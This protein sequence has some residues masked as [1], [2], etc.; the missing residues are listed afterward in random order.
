MIYVTEKDKLV[1]V[2]SDYAW[3]PPLGELG[4]TTFSVIL[5]HWLH[6][7]KHD[8]TVY[9][10]NYIPECATLY[11]FQTYTQKGGYEKLSVST[12]TSKSS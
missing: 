4:E 7:V 1:I 11:I 3:M 12:A 6:Q 10:L 2:D 8:F 9:T 5:A